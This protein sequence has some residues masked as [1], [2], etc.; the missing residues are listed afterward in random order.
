M[1]LRTDVKEGVSYQ[2]ALCQDSDGR[3]RYEL[4][5]AGGVP[6]DAAAFMTRVV[7]T[8]LLLRR[9]FLG[10]AEMVL[11]TSGE[12]FFVEAHGIWLTRAEVEVIQAKGW[13]NVPWLNG[14]APRF[15]PQ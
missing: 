8:D 15:P 3:R 7:P 2:V 11:L 10:I 13:R 12:P 4:V 6:P 1:W 14:L 5:I 9:D